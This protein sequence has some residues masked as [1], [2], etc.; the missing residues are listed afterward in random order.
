MILFMEWMDELNEA[1]K[2]GKPRHAPIPHHDIE[3]WLKSVELLA[4]DLE[5]LKKSRKQAAERFA[6]LAKKKKEDE[7]KKKKEKII[8]KLNNDEESEEPEET[9]K[10]SDTSDKFR[11]IKSQRRKDG[12]RNEPE[13]SDDSLKQIKSQRRKDRIPK[14]KK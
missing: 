3:R 12:S 9:K 1:R 2:K 6:K 8:K 11:N 5:D 13:E 10:K 4:K 14:D 7:E